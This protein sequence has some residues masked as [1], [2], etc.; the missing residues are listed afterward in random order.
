MSDIISNEPNWAAPSGEL[1]QLSEVNLSPE[2]AE[3]HKI[4]GLNSKIGQE[5]DKWKVEVTLRDAT[6]QGGQ[7]VVT[8]LERKTKGDRF[9]YVANEL[10]VDGVSL[11]EIFKN[12]FI[13]ITSPE[14]VKDSD[15]QVDMVEHLRKFIGTTAF[16]EGLIRVASLNDGDGLAG[17]FHEIGHTRDNLPSIFGELDFYTVKEYIKEDNKKYRKKEL[18]EIKQSAEN[19][20]IYEM[21]AHKF[22][23]KALDFLRDKGSDLFKDD[24]DLVRVKKFFITTTMARFNSVPKF[25]E[26][27]GRER[28]NEILNL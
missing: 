8:E 22:A 23:I 19:I 13:F 25:T 1:S 21:K 24:E 5:D 14:D 12:R 2:R 20:L 4:F 6:C 11:P 17:L 9:W 15:D 18:S 7:L 26:L 28:I 3:L 27:V 16:D 10:K